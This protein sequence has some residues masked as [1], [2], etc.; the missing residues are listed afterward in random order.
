MSKSRQNKNNFICSTIEDLGT[1]RSNCV[2]LGETSNFKE[3]VN[4][5]ICSTVPSE[6]VEQ[7]FKLLS[8]LENFQTRHKICSNEVHFTSWNNLIGIKI[9][10]ETKGGNRKKS[11]PD[12]FPFA[13]KET[14]FLF[15]LECFF[16]WSWK[17]KVAEA[18]SE[19]PKSR[20]DPQQKTLSHF[21]GPLT[22]D[23]RIRLVII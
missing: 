14:F 15:F 8:K 16:I 7:Q 10:T 11:G 20:D 17:K 13:T 22:V 21:W 9:M 3:N 2:E 12:L 5:L 23:V 18:F 19:R 6:P 1:R 4:N